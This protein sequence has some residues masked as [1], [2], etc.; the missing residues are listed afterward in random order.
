MIVGAP[1]GSDVWFGLIRPG[2]VEDMANPDIVNPP[3]T[4]SSR[5][6]FHFCHFGINFR[7]APL[8]DVNF[9][10]ALAHLVPK[11]RIIGTLFRFVNVRVDTCVPPAQALFYNAFVDAQEYSPASAEAIL[12]AGGYVKTGG[13]WTYGDGSPLEVRKI[14]CPTEVTA[15]TSYTIARM[16][17]DECAAI[18]LTNMQLEPMDFSTYLIKVFDEWDFD[19]YWVCWSLG[20]FADHLYDMAHSSQNYLGSNNPTGINWPALDTQLAT[21]KFSL[22]ESD[23]FAA[24]KVAQEMLQGGGQTIGD[25]AIPAQADRAM[26]L[27][28]IP[29]YSRNYYDVYDPRLRGMVNEF[30]YGI[31]NGYSQM[32]CYWDTTNNYRPGTTERMIVHIEDEYPETLNP[33][34]AK[35]VYAW[36]VMNPN[37]DGLIAVQPWTH[38]DMPWLA[39]SWSVAP[40]TGPETGGVSGMKIDFNLRTDVDWADGQHFDASDVV[41]AWEW[42]RDWQIPRYLGSTVYLH[43]VTSSGPTQVTAYL[44]TTSPWYVYDLAGYA[45]LFPPQVWQNDFRNGL[46]WANQAAILGCDPSAQSPGPNGLPSYLFGTGAFI[47]QSSTQ[48][49]ANLGYGD[50]GA[51]P[52]YWMSTQEILDLL[53]SWFH[54]SGDVT[55]TDRDTAYDKAVTITDLNDIGDSFDT[56]STQPAF[57]TDCDIVGVSGGPPDNKIDIDDLSTSARFF[58]ETEFSPA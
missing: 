18:G 28:Y 20:R 22:V 13:V 56:I 45:A 57:D 49:F 41:F 19:M 40:F 39:T 17:T 34:Q 9:R 1:T 35:T 4:I 46:P 29:V 11:D 26:A 31:D 12:A 58:A 23:R 48:E 32:A 25:L 7:R 3:K 47:L 6:G 33:A 10:H 36:D 38:R 24:A 50:D 51:N 8:D 27:P 5:S 44:N 43:T 30:G 37:F 55:G 21:L 53:G 16:V 42:L 15:P 14:Y 2:D 52:N 54:S